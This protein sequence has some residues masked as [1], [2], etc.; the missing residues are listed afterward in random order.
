MARDS[1]KS[2]REIFA[3]AV[4][5]Y[6][7]AQTVRLNTE[8]AA[9]ARYKQRQREVQV[10]VQEETQEL[11]VRRRTATVVAEAEQERGKRLVE[12]TEALSLAA[13]ALLERAGLAEI[14]G[15]PLQLA[16]EVATIRRADEEVASAFTAAHLAHADLRL[17]M[18][19]LGQSLAEA[20]QWDVAIRVIDPLLDGAPGP[21]TTEARAL[22]CENHYVT[23]LKLLANGDWLA[24]RQALQVVIDID[25]H[26]KEARSMLRATYI[27][28]AHRAGERGRWEDAQEHLLGWLIEHGDDVE[29]RSLTCEAYGHSIRQALDGK[30]IDQAARFVLAAQA[31]Q[32]D[33]PELRTLMAG[34]SSLRWAAGIMTVAQQ[35]APIDETALAVDLA[36][37]WQF[38]AAGCPDKRVRVWES[39]T[40]T[41]EHNLWEHFGEVHAVAYS[42]DG[43]FLASG[44]A[45][46]AVTVWQLPTEEVRRKLK[47]HR[48]AV[49]CVTISPDNRWLASGGEDQ[50]VRIW[51]LQSGKP[52]HV[53]VAHGGTVTTLCFSPDG[54][55]LASG[56]ADATIVVWDVDTVQETQ[57]LTGHVGGVFCVAFSPDGQS[58]GSG[59]ED[60]TIRL[61][62]PV[63]GHLRQSFEG[64]RSRVISLAFSPDSQLLASGGKDSS[65]RLWSVVTG[66]TLQTINGL[67][68]AAASVRFAPDGALLAC[69]TSDLA[70]YVWRPAF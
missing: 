49:K 2:L 55:L 42:E 3:E 17:A 58:L 63:D 5:A 56:A 64:H 11:R 62:E 20:G 70:V 9:E 47:G 54:A 45:D 4:Q 19:G 35:S 34:T 18:L 7:L 69:G 50:A 24:A 36:P 27:Q 16:D 66:T 22:L 38:V 14:A 40:A 21:V 46:K 6:E 29:V 15:A 68:G 1:A 43:Q 48:A 8:K 61:W 37:N 51:D 12:A 67:N 53:L 60:R 41:L 57:T 10:S 39:A 44:S 30:R 65:V 13:R 23:A 26:Y 59:G 25:L 31:L 28:A 52:R 32:P 33:W